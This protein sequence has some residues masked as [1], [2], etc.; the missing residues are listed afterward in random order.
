M[1]R[2]KFLIFIIIIISIIFIIPVTS[3][4][5]INNNGI[6]RQLVE[7]SINLDTNTDKVTE[8]NDNTTDIEYKNENS[9]K[10]I[11]QQ[12]DI[13][14]DLTLKDNNINNLEYDFKSIE[15]Y[16]G[17]LVYK[18]KYPIFNNN[19]INEKVYNHIEL[20]SENF[21][22]EFSYYEPTS[23]EDKLI[24]KL[25]TDISIFKDNILSVKFTIERNYNTYP[26]PI[27]FYETYIIDIKEN[28]ELNLEDILNKG[29][30]DLFY[31][32]SKEYFFNTYG[33]NI[34]KQSENYNDIKPD[35]NVYNKIFIKDDIVEIFIYDYKKQE[36]TLIKIPMDKLLPYVKKEY[37]EI[38]QSTTQI[39]TIIE[40]ITETT[41]IVIEETSTETTTSIRENIQNSKSNKRKID[42][43]KPMIALTFDD[44][45]NNATTNR[46]LDILEQNNSVATFFV[47]SRRIEKDV[48]I[49]K[50]MDSLG[51][52]IGN[53]TANH[54]DLTKLSNEQIKLE[55][56]I[57]NDKLEKAI[58]K[59]ATIVRVP[60][61]AINQTIKET[62]KYPI[63]M[64]NV[65]TKDWQSKNAK[66]IEQQVLTKVKDGD[67]ILMHDLYNT[68]AEAC[69]VIIPKL[70]EQGF[71]LVTV[72]ELLEYKGIYIKNGN[73]YFNGNM[74]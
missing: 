54:K 26:N 40:T 45:P 6:K 70:I 1:K 22:T 24:F 56:D 33:I 9:K 16:E 72:E 15:K 38:T 46:I 30:E 74:K 47:V 42:K 69:E 18:I 32:V 44:G 12:K 49:L 35:K 71:Q 29:Y 52:Q 10:I 41:T 60:Y 19:N 58:G 11:V 57:V 2:V 67:I 13:R 37:I 7:A 66:D 39:T 34:T 5:D 48:E 21:K 50:R 17:Y 25:D 51:C 43:N 27:K 14:D 53:H 3:I 20:L 68:T 61:G 59:Q 62:I 36:E 8:Q 65:D 63:I 64:W 23:I 31:I 73:T 4:G 28:K 55:V